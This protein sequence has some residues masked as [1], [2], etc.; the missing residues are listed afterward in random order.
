MNLL[1][2]FAILWMLV[3]VSEVYAQQ[4]A[5]AQE[6]HFRRG[7]LRFIVQPDAEILIEQVQQDFVFGAPL[8]RDAWLAAWPASE[9]EKY[10][11]LFSENFTA[12]YLLSELN[13]VNAEKTRDRPDYVYADRMVR[14]CIEKGMVVR[15]PVVISGLVN[16]Y[17]A[18]LRGLASTDFEARIERRVKSLLTYY[19]GKISEYDLIGQVMQSTVLQEKC[20]ES[21]Y[22]RIFEWARSADPN[23]FFYL[24][25]RLKPESPEADVFLAFL[26]K[27][28]AMG[29]RPD[30][31]SLHADIQDENSL[32]GLITVLDHLQKAN[33]PVKITLSVLISGDDG[34]AGLF[35]K[36]L[37]L[38][39]T[40]PATEGLLLPQFRK[41][42][43]AQKTER[44]ELSGRVYL[45]DERW[46]PS[47]AYPVW[48]DLVLGKWQSAIRI[49]A[50]REGRAE[51]RPLFGKLKISSGTKSVEVVLKPGDSVNTIIL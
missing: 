50:D 36:A 18:W 44:Q 37:R 46:N 21:I 42:M 34:G 6:D 45:W 10:L 9:R 2:F 30:G 27:L 48:A 28:L 51:A 12:G 14:W 19:R 1:R 29:V 4:D 33:L 17:P 22:A 5:P 8:V 16:E 15:G 47:P 40:H 39:Y 35:E 41:E 11:Q 23:A 7:T 32:A 20:G 31:V 26:G 3:H 24:Q 13:W 49:T 38:C 25:E 43:A